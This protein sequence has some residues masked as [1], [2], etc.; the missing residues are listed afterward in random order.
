MKISDIHLQISL[1]CPINGVN[2]NGEIDF[3]EEATA[4]ERDS[5]RDLIDQLIKELE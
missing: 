4:P 2:S 1:I 5:A 3:K